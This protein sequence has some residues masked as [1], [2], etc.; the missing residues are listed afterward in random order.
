MLRK[1]QENREP[2]ELPTDLEILSAEER[3]LFRKM[4]LSMKPF[5]LLGKGCYLLNPIVSL[6]IERITNTFLFREARCF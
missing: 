4:G 5:L 6:R 1:L 3:F 2:S